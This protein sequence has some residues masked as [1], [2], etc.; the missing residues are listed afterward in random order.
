MATR[1]VD[2]TT[3]PSNVVAGLSLVVGTSYTLQNVDANARIFVR[4]AAVKP[5]GGALRGF[6]VR[7]FEDVTISPVANVGIWL[8]CDRTDGAKAVIDEVA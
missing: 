6:V 1:N 7:P 3:D 4:V 5:T 8:W 2:L